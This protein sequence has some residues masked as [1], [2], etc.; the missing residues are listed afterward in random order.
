RFC[1]AIQKLSDDLVARA[2][3]PQ[4]VR[5][6]DAIVPAALHLA[7]AQQQ[8]AEGVAEAAAH[9]ADRDAR[10]EILWQELR[11]LRAGDDHAPAAAILGEQEGIRARA[12]LSRRA[13]PPRRRG[14]AARVHRAD[15]RVQQIDALEE[16]RP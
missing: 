16:E 5:T 8:A 7:R 2:P 1:I 15:R 12:A 4:K 11:A 3:L 13:H 14:H 6:D 9:A 10:A